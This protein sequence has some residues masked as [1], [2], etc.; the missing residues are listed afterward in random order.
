MKED[1]DFI[2]YKE[3]LLLAKGRFPFEIN[4]YTLMNNHSHLIMTIGNGSSLSEIM[5]WIN[6]IYSKDYN[7][8]HGRCS[9]FWRS[10]YKAKPIL[11]ERYA[12]ACLRYQHRNP[13]RAG[14][15]RDPADWPWSG[16]RFFAFGE[17]DPVITPHP[18]FLELS[19]DPRERCKFYRNLVLATLPYDD[20]EKE[21]F[22]LPS[23]GRPKKEPA[24][25]IDRIVLPA[26]DVVYS[27]AK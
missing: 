23:R 17:E 10:R 5:R 20:R 8:R 7:R 4:N 11:D 3:I 6:G 15:V 18:S 14:M 2:R 9:H 24:D 1:E 26:F 19:T 13:L 22:A 12:L 21:A 25:F 27:L 16:Y